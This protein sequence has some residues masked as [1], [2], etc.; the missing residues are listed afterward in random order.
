MPDEGDISILLLNTFGYTPY[1]GYN[2]QT[3]N[4]TDSQTNKLTSVT[5]CLMREISVS[6]FLTHLAMYCTVDTTHKQTKQTHKQTNKQT[7]LSL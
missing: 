7:N 5:K 4:K 6:C 1:D 3:N 2:T